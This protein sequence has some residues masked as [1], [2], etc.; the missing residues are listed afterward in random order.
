MQL[1]ATIAKPGAIEYGRS[2]IDMRPFIRSPSRRRRLFLRY[3]QVPK[4]RWVEQQ[5]QRA[6]IRLIERHDCSTQRS[7]IIVPGNLKTL[8]DI[9]NQIVID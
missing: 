9:S 1:R 7:S 3:W 2:S 8:R 6:L 5:I 4:K